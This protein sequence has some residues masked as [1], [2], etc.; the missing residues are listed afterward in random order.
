MS[1]KPGLLGKMKKVVA[2]GATGVECSLVK[3]QLRSSL[4]K[5]HIQRAFTP[6]PIELLKV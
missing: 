1:K 2:A 6:P 4:L 3:Y 5:N